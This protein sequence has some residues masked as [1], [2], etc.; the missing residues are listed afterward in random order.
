MDRPTLSRGLREHHRKLTRS[1]QAV[2]ETLAQANR[3]LTPAE[4]YRRAKIKYPHLGLTTVYRT[5][6][7]LVELGYIQRVHFAAGC[8][9][10]A[11]I[12]QAHGHHLICSVCG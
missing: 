11:L 1:R 12:A 4:L 2:L 5:L 9:S 6:D 10:Y 8:H 3:H 7:L